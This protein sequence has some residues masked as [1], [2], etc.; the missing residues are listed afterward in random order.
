[1][2]T[3]YLIAVVLLACLAILDLVVGVSNDAV[4]FLNSSIGS[5]VASR[6]TIMIIA[7]FGILLGAISSSGM[8]EVARKGIMN[9]EF[10]TFA[11]IMVIFLAVMLTDILLLDVFNTLGMPT[12]TTVSIVFE[13]LGASVFVS[14]LKLFDS[15]QDI[16]LLG[17]YVNS[18]NALLIISGILLSVVVAF[19]VGAFVQYFSRLLFSFDYMKKIKTVG[20]IWC[21]LALTAMLYFLIFKGL[22]QVPKDIQALL[23]FDYIK[24]HIALSLLVIFVISTILMQILV[25]LKIN[26]F[27]IIVLSGTFA[28]AMAFSGNDLVNFI[29]VPVAGFQAWE[30]WTASGL[31]ADQ[32]T[33]ESMA[34]KVPTPYFLLVLAGGIMVLTLWFSKKARSV[35]ETEV[36]LGRQDEGAERFAPNP[37]ARNLVRSFREAGTGIFKLFPKRTLAKMERNFKQT[38]E[39]DPDVAFD[40]IRAAVNLTVASILIAI[41]SN[42]KLPLSTT[43]VSFMVAMG[44]SLSDRA[45]DRESA[46]YRVSG[47]MHVIG[48]WF[49]TAFIAFFTAGIFATLIYYLNFWAVGALVILAGYALYHSSKSHKEKETK[50]VKKAIEKQAHDEFDSLTIT[51]SIEKSS[52]H[53]ENIINQIET[54]YQLALDGLFTENT[55]KV[56]KAEKQLFNLKEEFFDLEDSLIK[57]IKKTKTEDP[58]AGR[59]YIKVFDRLDDAINSLELINGK[60]VNHVVNSHKPLKPVQAKNLTRISTL[61]TQYFDQVRKHIDEKSFTDIADIKATKAEIRS[62]VDDQL[63][64][65]VNGIVQKHYGNKNSRLSLVILLESKDFVEDIDSLMDLYHDVQSKSN[66]EEN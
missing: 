29:G 28:L 10:F 50:K 36:N 53:I 65:Q 51:K 27:K 14:I 45:W 61:I 12:S 11:E 55:K 32:F 46:V 38:E 52:S 5:K 57:V 66:L 17:Q 24:D 21:G 26:I 63:N 19:S 58:T 59:V 31:P 47:V 40:L 23:Y 54:T 48:G 2:E 30:A 6:K 22:K 64:Y 37:M 4:N 20:V 3:F 9:P 8:M 44:T 60:I 35:T 42:L 7:S 13:L 33:M 39:Q 18:G 49:L 15:H 56:K 41:A 1:M 25:L 62:I 43:Y 16:N 34:G